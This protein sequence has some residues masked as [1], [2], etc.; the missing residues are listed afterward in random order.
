MP[1]DTRA[2]REAMAGP[3]T[4]GFIN[5]FQQNSRIMEFHQIRASGGFPSPNAASR[6]P[7][8]I[9]AP[10]LESSPEVRGSTRISSFRLPEILRG[11]RD[12]VVSS[13]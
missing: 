9:G 11:Q 7:P 10:G 6:L 5:S 2:A 4:V 13:E 12:G 8:L 3:H 1:L